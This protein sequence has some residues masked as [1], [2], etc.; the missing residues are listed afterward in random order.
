M[1]ISFPSK[2]F[3]NSSHSAIICDNQIISYCQ[4]FRAVSR[5]IGQL[6]ALGI[7]PDNRVGIVSP[8]SIE[9]IVTLLSLWSIKAIACPLN[10]RLPAQIIESQ[11]C[12][13][14]AKHLITSEDA[15]VQSNMIT[16]KKVHLSQISNSKI[17][18]NNS[19]SVVD[20]IDDDRNATILFT[21]G[22]SGKP[23]AV[24]HT[25]YN[26]IYSAQ[27]SNELIPVVTGD[28][29]LLSL[30]LYHVSGLS[31]LFRTL[32]FGGA[33]VLPKSNTNIARTIDQ[34]NCT[35]ISLVSTQFIRLL[36]D[37][38]LCLK[39]QDLKAILIGGSNIPSSLLERSMTMNLP[40]YITYGSTEM[41]SQVATAKHP[42]AAKALNYR[43]IA[44]SPEGEILANGETLFAGYVKGD[45]V[46]LPLTSDGWF[47]TGD[48]GT[49]NEEGGLTV[50]GRKDNM[51][52]S[53]GENIH[54]EEIERSLTQVSSVE[55]AIV[56]PV[57]NIEFGFRPVA[58]IK[59]YRD[60]PVEQQEL[61]N[62]LKD[63]FPR[64][65]IPEIFYIW[66]TQSST[67]DLIIDRPYLIKKAQERR[68][69]LKQIH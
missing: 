18:D 27:G 22:S 61:F 64:F 10:T 50:T 26:H 24:L 29:W 59:T 55:K 42:L 31:I 43:K 28:R 53:G 19:S 35:H 66:P 56:V 58:F 1:I 46:D 39:L 11:L 69:S 67:E 40:I 2:K 65:K 45:V 34:Q 38:K 48:V 41:A 20:V 9:Y 14:N 12:H 32:L 3:L 23:K 17:P 60:T 4:L 7:R 47:A 15:L 25:L 57:K 44:I 5:C 6:R 37:K 33:I 8:N 62:I 13:I 51:F 36:E 52:I 49:I 30:P 68:A 63:Q 16:A 21:S 54:P